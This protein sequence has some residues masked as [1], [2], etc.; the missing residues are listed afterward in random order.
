[1]EEEKKKLNHKPKSRGN[2]TGTAYKEKGAWTAEVTLGYTVDKDG[3]QQRVKRKK[4][5]F[6]TKTAALEYLPVVRNEPVSAA[7]IT[8]N[9]LWEVYRDNSLPKLSKS[10]QGQYKTAYNKMRR[11]MFMDI[12]YIDIETLQRTVNE[13]A[14][15]YYPA[16]D[17]KAILCHLYDRAVAQQIVNV[18][19][20]SYIELPKK[21]E[22]IPN[23]FTEDEVKSL[24]RDYYSGNYTT[25][26]ALLMIYTGMMP[27]E[28]FE[29][30]TAN[31]DL[32]KQ[33]I[34]GAGKKTKKRRETP[35]VLAECILPVIREL[36]QHTKNDM[37]LP[38]NRDAYRSEFR[39]M[40]ERCG[41]RKDLVP[42]SCRHTTATSLALNDIAMPIIKEVMRHTKI[43]TTQRYIHVDAEP[44]LQA[45]NK[46]QATD[47][48]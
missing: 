9:S 33:L 23:P 27:G 10:K 39:L 28:L 25:G 38:M 21:D 41:C 24:W 12:K 4:R 31:I 13:A 17:M 5:G 2:G 35:M 34:I 11:L 26:Y 42:Y 40:L 18:N 8:L 47:Q 36:I 16:R 1:M 29:L 6:K 32:E 22:D 14:P 19:I 15:T 48:K 45:V 37:F 30:K 44:M 46:L 43:T 7:K 3:K 20:A